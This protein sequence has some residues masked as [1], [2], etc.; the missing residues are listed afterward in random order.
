MQKKSNVKNTLLE[1]PLLVFVHISKCGGTTMMDILGNLYYQHGSLDNKRESF[2][3]NNGHIYKN[4]VV[5]RPWGKTP[6]SVA[7]YH[8]L[9]QRIKN[10][11]L[12]I[13]GGLGT[14]HEINRACKYITILRHPVERVISYYYWAVRRG[15]V[16]ANSIGEYIINNKLSL[17]HHIG[18]GVDVEHDNMMTRHLVNAKEDLGFG[19]LSPNHLY[20][21]KK[22]LDKYFDVAGI[23]QRYDESLVLMKNILGWNLMPT[24]EKKKVGSYREEIDKETMGAIIDCILDIKLYD[25]AVG[26]LNRLIKENKYSFNRDMEKFEKINKSYQLRRHIQNRVSSFIDSK[27]I[28][29]FFMRHS[30]DLML[31]LRTQK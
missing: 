4:G 24:Y 11:I 27:R 29:Q 25:Y 9:P 28:F 18:E 15:K 31:F 20:Q 5:L 19:K 14:H 8:Q 1:K 21:A 26:K 23:M 6:V 13:Q 10:D 17:L 30:K 22:N 2:R 7:E 3:L 16:G 12:V